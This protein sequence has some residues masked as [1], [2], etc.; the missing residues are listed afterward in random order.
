MSLTFDVHTDPCEDGYFGFLTYYF[1]SPV[2]V[3]DHS[4][5]ITVQYTTDGSL[6][7]EFSSSEAF[8][9]ASATWS[10][11]SGPIIAVNGEGCAATKNDRCYY[12]CQDIQIDEANQVIVAFG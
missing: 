9:K 6:R 11:D 2:V 1:N 10:F 8:A 4:S 12:Y 7:V 3:L 5:L